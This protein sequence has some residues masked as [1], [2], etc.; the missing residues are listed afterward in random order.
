[1]DYSPVS[2]SSGYYFHQFFTSR[3]LKLSHLP[4]FIGS[5]FMSKNSLHSS[6]RISMLISSSFIVTRSSVNVITLCNV[7]LILTPMFLDFSFSISWSITRLNKSGERRQPCLTSEFILIFQ[8]V[9]LPTD[10]S[11]FVLVYISSIVPITWVGTPFLTDTFL[12][13][14]RD[15]ASKAFARSNKTMFISLRYFLCCLITYCKVLTVSKQLSTGTNSF[16]HLSNMI[17]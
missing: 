5:S 7:P 2:V 10:I 13:L 16:C 15:I 9:L 4:A 12:I 1:M 6:I 14:S 17:L 8:V 3:T 11:V